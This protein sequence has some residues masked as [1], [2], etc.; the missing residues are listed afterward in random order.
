MRP[1]D[2]F[3][4]PSQ[5]VNNGELSLNRDHLLPLRRRTF[6]C[7]HWIPNGSANREQIRRGRALSLGVGGG[8]FAT[9]SSVISLHDHR[10]RVLFLIYSG[11]MPSRE[12]TLRRAPSCSVADSASIDVTDPLR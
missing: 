5:L 8:P 4:A 7:Q 6:T 2:Q 3:D 10:T 11:Q 9:N 1:S 12:I